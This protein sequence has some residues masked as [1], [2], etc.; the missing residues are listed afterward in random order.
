MGLEDTKLTLIHKAAH[1][2][3][4]AQLVANRAMNVLEGL[5][6]ELL[7]GEAAEAVADLIEIRVNDQDPPPTVEEVAAVLGRVEG[8]ESAARLASGAERI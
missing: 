6:S 2:A 8:G 1:T 3:Y 7:G 4:G 5:T